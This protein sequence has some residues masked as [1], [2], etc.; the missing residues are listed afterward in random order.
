LHLQSAAEVEATCCV[1]LLAG[2]AVQLSL[3]SVL[4]YVS[5]GH[6]THTPLLGPL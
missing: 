4:L 2:Q 1:T 3:P 5:S 6:A